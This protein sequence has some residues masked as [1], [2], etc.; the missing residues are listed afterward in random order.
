MDQVFVKWPDE[1]LQLCWLTLSGE[2]KMHY[3]YYLRQTFVARLE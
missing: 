1:H 3:K 2:I